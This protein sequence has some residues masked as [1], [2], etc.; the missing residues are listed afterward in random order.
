MVGISIKSVANKCSVWLP[1]EIKSIEAVHLTQRQQMTSMYFHLT[2]VLITTNLYSAFGKM[3]ERYTFYRGW[4]RVVYMCE[5]CVDIF[6]HYTQMSD[7]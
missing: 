2:A 6:S 4:P 1:I 3:R 7:M 5:V